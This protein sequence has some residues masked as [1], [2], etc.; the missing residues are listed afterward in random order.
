MSAALTHPASNLSKTSLRLDVFVCYALAVKRMKFKTNLVFSSWLLL[1][2]SRIPIKTWMWTNSG[3]QLPSI[4]SKRESVKLSKGWTLYFIDG[5][6]REMG[7]GSK[8]PLFS[9][10]SGP[11]NLKPTTAST[12]AGLNNRGVLLH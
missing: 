3:Y 10:A 12:E 2:V 7:H 9:L 1:I 8:A 6:Y 5:E 11:P 4:L